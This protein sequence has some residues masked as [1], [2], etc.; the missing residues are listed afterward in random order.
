MSKLMS[1]AES[2]LAEYKTFKKETVLST[3]RSD[4]IGD[5][6]LSGKVDA[7]IRGMVIKEKIEEIDHY[8]SDKV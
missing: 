8:I 2:K 6:V 1:E 3:I 7:A 4:T 5:E